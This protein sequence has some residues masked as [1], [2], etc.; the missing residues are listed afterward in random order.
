[1][2]IILENGLERIAVTSLKSSAALN[3]VKINVIEKTIMYLTQ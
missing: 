3:F 1:M 2:F